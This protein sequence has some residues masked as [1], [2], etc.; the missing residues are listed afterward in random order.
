MA[1]TAA[2]ANATAASLLASAREHKRAVNVHRRAARADME[3][4][5]RLRDACRAAGIQ[6]VI[7][8]EAETRERTDHQA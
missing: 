7:A 2:E 6:L 8:Q 5:A 1:L 3:A 4:L